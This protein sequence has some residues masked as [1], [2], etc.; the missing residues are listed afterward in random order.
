MCGSFILAEQKRL[1]AK[2]V[3]IWRAASLGWVWRSCRLGMRSVKPCQTSYSLTTYIRECMEI[4]R[5]NSNCIQDP[6]ILTP[7]KWTINIWLW[8]ISSAWSKPVWK[9]SHSTGFWCTLQYPAD[10]IKILS[11]NVVVRCEGDV[12][13]CYHKLTFNNLGLCPYLNQ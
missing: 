4:S 13:V 1:A 7:P 6:N 10:T 5:T 8:I 11:F 3:I 12:D 2:H 9:L